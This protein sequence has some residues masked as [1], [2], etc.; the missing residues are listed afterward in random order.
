MA[1][2]AKDRLFQSRKMAD[3]GISFVPHCLQA[4]SPDFSHPHWS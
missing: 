1:A 3:S 2:L 4:V